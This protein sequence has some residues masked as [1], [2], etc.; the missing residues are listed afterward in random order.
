MAL[1]S[2]YDIFRITEGLSAEKKDWISI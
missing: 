1:V 2:S